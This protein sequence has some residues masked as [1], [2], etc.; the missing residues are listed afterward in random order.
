MDVFQGEFK[1]DEH[2]KKYL[3]KLGTLR[4]VQSTSIP[5]Y[6]LSLGSPIKVRILA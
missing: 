1:D 6:K 5:S 2:V 4:D 3:M